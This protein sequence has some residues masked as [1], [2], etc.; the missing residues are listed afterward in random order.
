MEAGVLFSAML[1]PLAL[2]CLFSLDVKRSVDSALLPSCALFRSRSN[3]RYS[4]N[5]LPVA[6]LMPDA[7]DTVSSIYIPMY[8]RMPLVIGKSF[9]SSSPN[10]KA[11]SLL[12]RSNAPPGAR[13]RH[14]VA[15]LSSSKPI[16]FV[17]F[18]WMND[19]K[20]CVS[21]H[22]ISED[23][24]YRGR[25]IIVDGPTTPLS[26]IPSDISMR[27][28]HQEFRVPYHAKL[29]LE[30]GWKDKRNSWESWVGLFARL[31]SGQMSVRTNY[32]ISDKG[33]IGEVQGEFISNLNET[34]AMGRTVGTSSAMN[35][36]ILE[37]LHMNGL[38][39]S[40][41]SQDENIV[42]K[43][44]QRMLDDDGDAPMSS[45]ATGG[46]DQ[47]VDV[48]EDNAIEDGDAADIAVGAPM[49]RYVEDEGVFRG[50]KGMQRWCDLRS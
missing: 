33:F 24:L 27:L 16:D 19:G 37:F 26:P 15:D 50:E 29:P 17:E 43:A 12:C 46:D 36:L 41:P 44:D 7:I 11:L 47:I 49:P 48:E 18:E 28:D 14:F 39:I 22:E 9:S 20:L 6:E 31:R 8:T 10:S 35:P 25:T 4:S 42:R 40:H 30:P 3:I 2:R 34:C 13:S 21:L 23:T 1:E 45:H 38:T 32:V 5:C